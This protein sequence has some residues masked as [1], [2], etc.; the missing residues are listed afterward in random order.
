MIAGQAGDSM[1]AAVIDNVAQSTM[2]LPGPVQ[3]TVEDDGI[4][5]VQ[6]SSVREFLVA[7]HVKRRKA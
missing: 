3:R 7:I 2:D 1:N 6:P 5:I 4:L